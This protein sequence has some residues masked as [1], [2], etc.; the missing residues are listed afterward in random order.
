MY[1]TY[2]S[3]PEVI[4]ISQ[5]PLGIACIIAAIELYKLRRVVEKISKNMKNA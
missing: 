1:S 3:T 5:I 4:L 2:M